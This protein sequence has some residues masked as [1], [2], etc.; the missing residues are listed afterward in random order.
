MTKNS[1]W[2]DLTKNWILLKDKMG[3]RMKDFNIWRVGGGRKKESVGVFEG[4]VDTPMH[5]LLRYYK[6]GWR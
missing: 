5:T 2:E 6:R 1:N 4:E 3:L